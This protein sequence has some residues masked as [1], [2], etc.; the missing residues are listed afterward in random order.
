MAFGCFNEVRILFFD[1]MFDRK[2]DVT[3]FSTLWSFQK[4]YYRIWTA[5]QLSEVNVRTVLKIRAIV[6]SSS[7]AFDF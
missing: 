6:S 4:S 5:I 3:V 2:A 1:L 7:L